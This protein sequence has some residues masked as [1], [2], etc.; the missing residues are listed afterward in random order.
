M[1]TKPVELLMRLSD[2]GNIDTVTDASSGGPTPQG[3][4]T[5]L[6]AW[7]PRR[8]KLTRNQTGA[9][10]PPAHVRV[11]GGTIDDED[12]D[13]IARK[14]GLRLGKFASTIERITVR[15]CDVNGPK[16]GCDQ[17][18]RIKVVLSGLPSVVV[19]ETDAALPRVID[20]AIDAV[21][22]AVGRRVQRRRLKPLHHRS[23]HTTTSRRA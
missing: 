18:C 4:R 23:T 6:P 1:N 11:G 9:T 14:L 10:S 17:Q 21:T 3:S 7:L 12:R 20:R 19:N 16:G 8:V 2:S 15:L 22:I 5:P 13:Y